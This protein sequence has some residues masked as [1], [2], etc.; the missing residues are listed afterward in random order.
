M[1]LE[2][3]SSPDEVFS[4]DACLVGAGDWCKGQYFFTEFPD[5]S[6]QLNLHSNALELLTVIVG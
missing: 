4:T 6:Y 1:A 2:E 3:W 5:F